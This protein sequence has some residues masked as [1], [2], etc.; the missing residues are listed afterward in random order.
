MRYWVYCIALLLIL[1]G[2]LF[3]FIGKQPIETDLLAL[4]PDVKQN[5]VAEQAADRL[6]SLLSERMIFLI[7]SQNSVEAKKSAEAFTTSLRESKAFKSV[8]AKINAPDLDSLINLYARYQN[9]LLVSDD[10]QA[11]IEG[12]E[13]LNKRLISR[14]ASPFAHGMISVS[15]DPFGFY[16]NWLGH[17]PYRNLRLQ[18]SDGW[19]MASQNDNTWILA[20]TALDGSPF[21][22]SIEEKSLHAVHEA[23][24]LLKKEYPDVKI[25]RA[26]TIFHSSVIRKRAEQEINLI[27]GVSLA[28]IILLIL[29][30]YRSL[31]VLSLGLLSVGTGICVG[32]LTTITIYGRI[33]LMTLIFGA[34]LLGEAIDYSIQYFSVRLGAGESWEPHSGLRNVSPRLMVALLTSILGYTALTLTPFPVLSQIGVFAISGLIASFITVV[35][36]FPF[37]LS[38]MQKI[39]PRR[40]L[41]LSGRFMTSYKDRLSKLHVMVIIT[42]IL[43]ISALGL[44]K[45]TSNDDIKLLVSLSPAL[46]QEEQQV[47]ELTGVS[48]SSQFILVEGSTDQ[49]VLENEENLGKLLIKE[50]IEM[51]GVSSYV[52]SCKKQTENRIIYKKRMADLKAIMSDIGFTDSAIHSMALTARNN[53]CMTVDRW[54]ASP[55]SK[56][57]E[58]MWMGKTQHG[59]ASIVLPSGYKSVGDLAMAVNGISGATVV[60][61]P[62]TISKLIGK[63]RRLAGWALIGAIA[64]VSLVLVVRYGLINGG[65]VLLPTVLSLLV[66]ASLLGYM[67]IP[68]TLF[69]VLALLLVVGVGVNYSI[70]LVEGIDQENSTTL[71]V[72]LSVLTAFLS[73]GLLSFSSMP[74]AHN[75]GVTLAIGLFGVALLSPISVVLKGK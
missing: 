21:T 49:E 40:L 53:D 1:A 73:F 68:I 11:L 31:K 37:A 7:G 39:L 29:S 70:F 74:A 17:L 6:T 15:K 44:F 26:G 38:D 28:G 36:V 50:G 22:P 5:P 69:H 8:Q 19:L 45:L 63:F 58:H 25:L 18:V 34:S 42:L 57:L 3:Q 9:G 54:L 64:L 27:G 61:K 47:R 35:M 43:L 20:S 66:T 33:H 55:I 2:L 71:G 16:S 56:P 30:A 14:L 23:T 52:P 65:G 48:G 60:D 32:L 75:F 24:A 72:L 13:V 59:Y 41:K 67:A 46:V 62:G 4:L 51:Q 10:L 12:K